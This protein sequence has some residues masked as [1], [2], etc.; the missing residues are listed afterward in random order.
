M[1]QRHTRYMYIQHISTHI[2]SRKKKLHTEWNS[3][4]LPFGCMF[5]ILPLPFFYFYILYFSF[6]LFIF[7]FPSIALYRLLFLPHFFISHFPVLLSIF[8]FFLFNF[9]FCKWKATN[10]KSSKWKTHLKNIQITVL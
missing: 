7:S 8:Y 6:F 9:Y 3:L 1:V 5:L 10:K 2:H 4:L